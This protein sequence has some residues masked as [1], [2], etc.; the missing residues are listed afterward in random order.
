MYSK[1]HT[2]ICS[3]C[4]YVG[5]TSGSGTFMTHFALP[6]YCRGCGETMHERLDDL[7][8]WEHQVETIKRTVKPLTWNPI[9]WLRLPT[10]EVVD[11]YKTHAR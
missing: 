1:V 2:A 4:G 7:P 8:H 3:N 10:F 6:K 5:G 9:S 11:S